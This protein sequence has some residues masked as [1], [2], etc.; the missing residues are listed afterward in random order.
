MV[1]GMA[2][3]GDV[4]RGEVVEA[5]AEVQKG[6]DAGGTGARRPLCVHPAPS[7]IEH[8]SALHMQEVIR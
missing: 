8:T 3:N 6:S 4:D 7:C 5:E 1:K 2:S